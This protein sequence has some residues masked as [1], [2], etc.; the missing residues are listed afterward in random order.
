MYFQIII[1]FKNGRIGA[2]STCAVL[3]PGRSRIVI[4]IPLHK[5]VS[6]KS[7]EGLGPSGQEAWC[8][9][10]GQFQEH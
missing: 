10:A 4:F 5:L 7:T 3:I 6:C 1:Y 9:R 2:S 8:G